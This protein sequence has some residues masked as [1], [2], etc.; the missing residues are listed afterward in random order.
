VLTRGSLARDYIPTL[1]Y[2]LSKDAK[3][4]PE[5]LAVASHVGANVI[6]RMIDRTADLNVTAG[7]AKRTALASAVAAEQTPLANIRLLL[8]KGANPN[9]SVIDGE[10]PL[11]WARHRADPARIELLESFGAKATQT[12]RDVTF[13]SP[14]GAP[15][16]LTALQRSVKAQC[17]SNV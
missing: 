17:R 13:P 7:A 6:S 2:L 12:P 5:D 1:D 15:D 9:L 16:V 4:Q 10:L 8:E 11:D 14:E 3:I